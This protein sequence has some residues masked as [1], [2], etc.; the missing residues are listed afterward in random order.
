MYCSTVLKRLLCLVLGLFVISLSL[1]AQA[2]ANKG[3]IIGTV[4]DP[5]E[6][7]VPHAK[8]T[9]RNVGT[10]AVREANTDDT[11]EFRALL[12]DPGKYEVTVNASGF[13]ETKLSDITLNVGSSVHL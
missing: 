3:R 13:A 8:V 11:G 10:G 4:L 2:D 6:A 7:V 12:L 1:W 5:K 9:I